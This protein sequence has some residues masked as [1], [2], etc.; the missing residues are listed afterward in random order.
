SRK[1][2]IDYVYVNIH[3]PTIA[4]GSLRVDGAV[5]PASQIIAHPNLP[6][7]SVALARFIGPAAQH[8]ITCDST[9]TATVYG[10]GNFESY[11]YNVGTL[12]NNLNYY[13]EIK[14]E[15]NITAN[16][17]TFTCPHSPVRL[18]LKVGYPVTSIHW[19]LSQVP[20]MSPNAD[21]IIINPMLVRT[22]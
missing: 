15:Y 5:V 14:N 11:G 9:F 16:T 13:S 1:S 2:A 18:F 6:S 22:E 10:L 3:V 7:Y 4:L 8:R 17:D 20:G 12:I 21:S 19:K